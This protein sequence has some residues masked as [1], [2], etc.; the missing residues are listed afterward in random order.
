MKN[1]THMKYITT[2]IYLLLLLVLTV[3]SCT[4]DNIIDA[5]H[6]PPPAVEG[7][8]A[9]AGNGEVTLTWNK[10]NTSLF[11]HYILTYTPSDGEPVIIP[12]TENSYTVFGLMNDTEYTFSLVAANTIQATTQSSETITVVV[13]PFEPNTAGPEITSFQFLAASNTDMA[14]DASDRVDLTGTI[15]LDNNTITFSDADVSAYIYRDKLVATFTAETG[16]TVTV[17]GTD[18]TSGTSVQDFTSPLQYVVTIDGKERIFT[19]TVNK[20]FFADIPD[21][22]F[23]TFLMSEGLPF[24]TENQLETNAQAVI[25]YKSGAKFDIDG[26]GI[27]NVKGIEFFV[28]IN[29]IDA[30]RNS[31]TTINISR[32]TVAKNLLIGLNSNINEIIVGDKTN[33]EIL[34]INFAPLLTEATIQP[35]ID[36]NPNIRRLYAPG[37]T[38]LTQLNVDNLT[39]MERLRLNESTATA[40]AASINTMLSKSPPVASDLGNLR[41]YKDAD[42]AQC[43]WDMTLNP[44]TFACQ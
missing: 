32:N 26:V 42:G 10:G 19:V 3:F 44:Y 18:Q 37:S 11:T 24:N 36:A 25:D 29:E 6:F 21:D 30:E 12:N 16:A 31:F 8:E 38:G 33:L 41:I 35:I 34:Y 17:D 22:A 27:S 28:N 43:T 9:V 40:S 39:K 15:D 14:L 20:N 13:T 1:I 4:E 7:F 23:R 2:P 5:P